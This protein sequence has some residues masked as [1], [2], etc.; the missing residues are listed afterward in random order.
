MGVNSCS[1]QCGKRLLEVLVVSDVFEP[2]D[3]F[4]VELFLNRDV[5][6]G[7]GGS[8]S[9][10]VLFA[11][12]EPDDIAGMDLLDGAALALSPATTRGDDE[13]LAEGMS[14]PRG[15]GAGLEGD[16]GALDEGRFGRLEQ[17]VNADCA[18]EPV[19]WTLGGCLRAD[20]LDLQ[21]LLL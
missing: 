9:V 3:D 17:R 4:A 20:S 5:G 2:V 14:M 18:G 7:G 10:P 11:R 15:A 6:H 19:R 16:A 13:G 21:N 12:R 8:G 1:G